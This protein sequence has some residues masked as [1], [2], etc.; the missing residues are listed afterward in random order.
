[1]NEKSLELQREGNTREKE[2]KEKKLFVHSPH[3]SFI[4]LQE[5]IWV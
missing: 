1:M 5:N 3:L 4:L 2:N